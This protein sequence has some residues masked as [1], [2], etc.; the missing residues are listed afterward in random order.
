MTK[1]P[2]EAVTKV[3]TAVL[4]TTAKVKGRKKKKA[5][6]EGD[7]METVSLGIFGPNFHIT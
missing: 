4:S 6:A 5:A 7:S 2:K 3:V 1:P